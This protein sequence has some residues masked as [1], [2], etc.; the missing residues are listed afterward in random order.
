VVRLQ[1]DFRALPLCSVGRLRVRSESQTPRQPSLPGS[2]L[3]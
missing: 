3:R 2:G 1:E